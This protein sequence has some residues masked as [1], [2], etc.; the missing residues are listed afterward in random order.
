[1]PRRNCTK[2]I[3]TL[4]VQIVAGI[5]SVETIGGTSLTTPG[6]NNELIHVTNT[7]SAEWDSVRYFAVDYD[8]G[9]DE[10]AG[11]SDVS[12][13]AAG[14]VAMKTIEE[15]LSRVP[16][17][18]NGKDVVIAIR[19]RA[20]GAVYLK[21]DGISPDQ[22]LID[23]F[24][25]YN[26]LLIR[27]TGTVAT[28]SAT[29]F[30]NDTADKISLGGQIFS[31]TNAG[32][33]NPVAPI[34]V[35]LFDV[36]LNGGGAPGLAAEPALI[37]KRIRFSS[38]TTTV[39]LR[40]ATA[41]IHANDTNTITVA[42]NLPATPVIT[43]IFYIEEPGM[44]VELFSISSMT[45]N[46]AI[47]TSL[48]PQG[49]QLVGIRFT[50]TGTS[51]STLYGPGTYR[52]S[53]V[54]TANNNLTSVSVLNFMDVQFIS[55]YFDEAGTS[56]TAG[57]GIR[58]IGGIN[59]SRG[60][61]ILVSSSSLTGS[62]VGRLQVSSA[63]RVIAGLGSYFF[64][65]VLYQSGKSGTTPTNI[66][67]DDT[68]GRGASTTSRRLRILSELGTPLT[69]LS[70][71]QTDCHV[72]GVDITGSA[73]G[74]VIALS[75]VGCNLSIDDVV[76]STGNLNN[77]LSLLNARDCNITMGTITSNTFIAAFGKDIVGLGSVNY[78]H[79]DYARTDLRDA[80][81]NHIQGTA[82]T[83]MGP[84][85]LVDNDGFGAIGKYMLVR[86]TASNA[87]RESI[88]TSSTT[89]AICGVTQ[90]SSAIGTSAII[91]N[92]GG[93]WVQFDGAPT[94]GNIG[95]LSVVNAGQAQD[96]TPSSAG[97]NQSV[98]I[99]RV[100]R[101]SGTLGYLNFNPEV[102]GGPTGFTGSNGPTGF[103]GSN[104]PTGFTGPAG[105][106]GLSNFGISNISIANTETVIISVSV[107]ANTLQIG[108]TFEF[109][110][111]CTKAGG[112]A[113]TPTI[114]IRVGPTTLTGN[115]AASLV[116]N[117]GSSAV[118]SRYRGVATIRTI[119][120]SGTAQG[121]LNGMKQ[122]TTPVVSVNSATV[123]VDSTIDNLFELTLI[124]GNAANTYVFR[125]YYVTQ[126]N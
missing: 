22:L 88:A 63:N 31:G 56:I 34:T 36:Q 7:L 26:Y 11:Y 20:A 61:Q 123:V 100:M 116:G 37:G 13:A 104:G 10:N 89:S 46:A 33:Y 77:G 23:G 19:N 122:A 12:L 106:V 27:G 98:P 52:L 107:P 41:M 49:I 120:A 58:S 117:G 126:I 14:T 48:S 66:V 59:C 91:V 1:M 44:A 96:T 32:G 35:E 3:I 6:E 83:M 65:G 18:G 69:G 43:D 5:Q 92:G 72:W 28:A 94:I 57:V 109:D 62:G 45:P 21:K 95:Y 93:T 76:G 114:R 8:A 54:D 90:C 99:G 68:I 39:A 108:S 103:T 112:N 17:C 4:G 29:A 42:D 113:A 60:I 53:F 119:T 84:I 80:G 9:N 47:N 50:G 40:N 86:P 38:T 115:I 24:Y 82:N 30:A 105:S 70:I 71:S 87:V 97:T 124:S 2:P 118:A 55:T 102:M 81:N 67:T 85:A 110:A 75:G 64:A 78:V 125:N 51:R 79:A 25:G 16:R 111:Y 73:A 74:S 15:M 121:S 101:A